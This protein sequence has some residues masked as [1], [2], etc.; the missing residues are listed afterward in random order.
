MPFWLKTDK[1]NEIA[2]GKLTLGE[3]TD[4]RQN[5]VR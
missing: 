5:D 2:E 4:S 1:V 3:L